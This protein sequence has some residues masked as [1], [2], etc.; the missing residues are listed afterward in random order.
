MVYAIC[1]KEGSKIEKMWG[2]QSIIPKMVLA[3]AGLFRLLTQ[4]IWFFNYA[5]PV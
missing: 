2:R 4:G 1:L 3:V 5:S